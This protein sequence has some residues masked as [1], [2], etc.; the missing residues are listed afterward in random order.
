MSLKDSVKH[1]MDQLEK[2]K[3]PYETASFLLLIVLLGYQWF[4]TINMYLYKAVN[5]ET[6]YRTAQTNLP[7]FINRIYAWGNQLGGFFAPVM[8]ILYLLLVFYLVWW[9]CHKRGYAKWTWTLLVLF[10]PN[11]FLIPA[12]VLYGAYAF[13]VYLYRFA[14]SIIEEFKAY[15]LKKDLAETKA[16][17]DAY[18]KEQAEKKAV[19][20]AEKAAAKAEKEAEKK[21]EE[22]EKEKEKEEPEF[23]VDEPVDM[24]DKYE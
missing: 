4:T 2:G 20:E 11:I 9:Y 8:Y 17:E 10:A 15:D 14:K 19:K 22:K 3:K 18:K 5:N 13:R 6:F 7:A 24:N 16:E 23:I 21:A 1:G 12:V